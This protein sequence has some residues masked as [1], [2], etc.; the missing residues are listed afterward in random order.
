MTREHGRS[1]G[2]GGR[3]CDVH[4]EHGS[5][6]P[7]EEYDAAT[8]EEIAEQDRRYRAA[9][10]D[11]GWIKRQLYKGIRPEAIAIFQMFAGAPDPDYPRLAEGDLGPDVEEISHEE[12]ES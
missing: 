10:N 11:P 8:L 3:H 2:V 4:G 6:Y 12:P 5:L 1:N 7:C 9:V